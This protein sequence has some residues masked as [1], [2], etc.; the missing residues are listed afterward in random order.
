MTDAEAQDSLANRRGHRRY[1]AWF[2]VALSEPDARTSARGTIVD[3]SL[4]GALVQSHQAVSPGARAT[5]TLTSNH[6][7]VTLA[8]QIIRVESSWTGHLLHM[9]FDS[10]D[11][12]TRL[13]LCKVLDDLERDFR[14]HQA[15]IA[16]ARHA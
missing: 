2:E 1:P 14:R 5:I 9:E 11:A 3:L 16:G 12:A 13:A 4:G 10:P 15:G 8:G 6:G 7:P